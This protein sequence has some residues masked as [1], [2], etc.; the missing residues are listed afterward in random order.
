[1]NN[2]LGFTNG[3]GDVFRVGCEYLDAIKGFLKLYLRMY[4]LDS[5]KLKTLK[6]KIRE[7]ASILYLVDHRENAREIYVN[8]E[9]ILSG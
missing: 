6:K 4:G 1:M 5:K 9:Y 2:T 8:D 3:L 7:K